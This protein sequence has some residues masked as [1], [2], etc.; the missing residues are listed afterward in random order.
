MANF[1]YKNIDEILSTALPVRGNRINL[2]DNRLLEKVSDVFQPEPPDTKSNNFEFHTFLTNGAYVS[3]I[4]NIQSWKINGDNMVLDIHRDMRRANNLPGVYKVVYNFL[5]NVVGGFDTSVKLFISD[6]SIDRRELKLSLL[7]E[8]SVEGKNQ[9]KNFVL[10]YL[11][12]SEVI[13]NYVLNFGENKISN[14]INVTSEGSPNS[15]YV[16]LYEPLPADLDLFFECWIAKEYMRP[17]IETVNYI[18]EEIDPELFELKGPN[19]EVDYDYWITTETEYKSWNDI[20]SSNVQTSQEILDRYISSSNLPVQLNVNYREFENFIF[21]SSA[22]DRVYN[23]FYKMQLIERYNNEIST[24]QTYTGS[25]DSNIVKVTGLRDKLISGFDNFEKWMYYE[26]TSSNYYTSQTGSTV[27]PYPKFEVT[28]SNFNIATKEGKYKFYPATSSQVETWYDNLILSASNYDL[29][30]YNALNKAIPDHVREDVD[31][32]QFTTFVNMIGQHFD[33]MYVYTDH[34]VKKN[35][36]EEHPKDGMS[37]DLIFEV[38][39]NLGWTLTSGTQAKDLWEY[40]LGV[41]GSGDPIWTGK[42]TT[43]KY[44][45]KSEEE[46]TK[47]VWRRVLNNLPYIYKSKGTARGVRALLAAYGIPQTLLTIREYGGPDNADLGKIARADFEKQTYYLN[48]KGS[49]PTPTTSSYVLVPWDRVN[50]A[51]G[52]WQYPDTVTFRWKMEPN[53]LYPYSLD[54]EQTLLQKNSGSRV[55]WFVTVNK[56]G[57]DVEKGSLTFYIGD[58]SSYKS[59]SIDDEYLYDDIPLN[60]MIRRSTSSDL[61]STNQT[62]DLFLKTNKYGKIAVERSA[63]VTVN[64]STDPNV[65]RA[66]VSSGDLYIGSGSNVQTNKILSGSIFELRYWSN[67]LLTSSFDNHVLSPRSYNGNTETSS[68]YDLQAQWKFWQRFDVAVTTSISSS[69]PD[70]TKTSFYES[71]KIANFVGF[72]IDSFESIVETYKMEVPTLGNNT[73][74]SEKVRIDSSSLYGGLDKDVRNEVSAFDTYSVDSDKLMIAFSPQHII[75]EDISEALGGVTLDDYIGSY[76]NVFKQEYPELKWLANQYWQKYNNRNDFTAYIRLISIF[77]FSVFD[78]IRQTLPARTNP[79]LGLVVEPNILERVKLDGTGRNFSGETGFSFE[80]NELETPAESKA[81]YNNLGS[82]SVLFD[83]TQEGDIQ[84][85][86]DDVDFSPQMPAVIQRYVGDRKVNNLT[87]EL[88]YTNK[89]TSIQDPVPEPKIEYK[90]K[91]TVINNVDVQPVVQY[92][93]KS[94]SISDVLLSPIIEYTKRDAQIVDT[95]IEPVVEYKKKDTVLTNQSPEL[96]S[97]N[98]KI[99]SLLNVDDSNTLPSTYITK[100]ARINNENSVI[101]FSGEYNTIEDYPEIDLNSKTQ[102][103]RQN[104]SYESGSID[105]GYGKGWKVSNNALMKSTGV[106]LNISGSRYDDFYKSYYLYYTASSVF[107]IPVVFS[108]SYK[109]ASIQNQN[110]LATANRRQRFEGCKFSGPDINVD[111]DETLDGTPVVEVFVVDSKEINY[112][113]Y[114]DGGNLEVK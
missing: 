107:N 89:E 94:G 102:Y 75:N 47:E 10:S 43:N 71:P 29:K 11:R 37:Q 104:V 69:H 103:I 100:F 62:Y 60:L 93:S 16:K 96:L 65:N 114:I 67:S 105:I 21:Y 59:A 40:A 39:R 108:S 9:L 7:N 14:I 41:S 42:T 30:N 77:D 19:F 6:I 12:P 90:T 111:S 110:T 45:A 80:S 31:N 4:Y 109:D 17:Y 2:D 83:G 87:P 58:G 3:T 52:T 51:N 15:L 35:L 50:N 22:E 66:W 82:V 63:S 113:T 61:T 34:I 24:L 95:L 5:Q 73:I 74:Y 54:P 92:T 81:T 53:K 101:K 56:N 38:A 78:Q 20:L 36:R 72:D 106:Y 84:D 27:T 88:K 57:T 86:T 76:S 91:N 68:F 18:A 48:F 70:Q 1:E 79:I 49:Y 26:T 8:D 28:G 25:T 85:L 98:N 64:G 23:F 46:R 33:I 13:E 112:R 55:D 44:L 99:D 32:E 97:E